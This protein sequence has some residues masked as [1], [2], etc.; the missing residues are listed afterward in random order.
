M[1]LSRARWRSRRCHV[2]AR[3]SLRRTGSALR[4]RRGPTSCRGDS[5]RARPQ[6]TSS[7]PLQS[8]A[9]A[10]RRVPAP[11]SGRTK[12]RYAADKYRFQVRGRVIEQDLYVAHPL[13]DLDD[14]EGRAAQFR[15]LG[16]RSCAGCSPRTSPGAL[17][18]H[19]GRVPAQARGRGSRPHV[20]R[21]GRT[22]AHEQALPLRLRGT[23][24]EAPLDRVRLGHAL[25][26]GSRSAPGHLRQGRQLGR[27]RGHASTTPR[28]STRA[29]ISR[30]RR[31]RCR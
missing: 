29:S 22:G 19:R 13:A 17:P 12:R 23:A 30:T 3:R 14:P 9:P 8:S 15:G 21:R 1:T 24:G 26:R 6:S 2:R 25:R 4:S 28:S 10:R 20:R 11:A 7:T 5:A 16:R 31:P 18:V 27:Q